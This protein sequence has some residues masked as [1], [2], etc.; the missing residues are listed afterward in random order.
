MGIYI[1]VNNWQGTGRFSQP[2]G[3]YASAVM[4]WEV[5]AQVHGIC[6]ALISNVHHG[7]H[8]DFSVQFLVF[9]AVVHVSWDLYQLIWDAAGCRP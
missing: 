5:N 3:W 6:L 7:N 1:F 4:A 8:T 9:L 2:W